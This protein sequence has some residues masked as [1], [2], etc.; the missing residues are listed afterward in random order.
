[1]QDVVTNAV[2]K[3]NFHYMFIIEK[4]PTVKLSRLLTIDF[5]VNYTPKPT[6]LNPV[7][8]RPLSTD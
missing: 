1:M 4:A 6:L 8:V 7:A 2:V 3:L 5:G